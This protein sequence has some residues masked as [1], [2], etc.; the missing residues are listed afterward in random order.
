MP[1]DVAESPD[2]IDLAPPDVLHYLEGNG[3]R[4][5]LDEREASAQF[6]QEE[7]VTP[8]YDR[9]LVKDKKRY[10]RFVKDLNQRGLLRFTLHPKEFVGVFFVWKKGRLKMR[11]I[12]DGRRPNRR[13]RRPPKARL[14]TSEGL[15]EIEVELPA[16]VDPLSP[17][18][19]ALLRALGLGL[20]VAD[21]ADC[22]HRMIMPTWMSAYFCVSSV[23]ARDVGLEGHSVDGVVLGQDNEVFPCA[24]ALPMGFSWSLWIAQRINEHRMSLC[25]CL[26]NSELIADNLPPAVFTAEKDSLDTSHFVCVDNLGVLSKDVGEV[27]CAMTEAGESFNSVDLKLHDFDITEDSKVTLGTQLDLKNLRSAVSLPR[28][29][30]LKMGLRHSLRRKTLSGWALEMLLGHCTFCGLT[31]RDL[32]CIFSTAY[33]FV[34]AHYFEVGTVWDTV[35]EELRMFH[36]RMCYLTSDWWLQWN[37]L[38]NESDASPYGNGVCTSQWPR[39]VVA[40]VGRLRER[41]RFKLRPGCSARSSALGAAGLESFDAV[42][43]LVDAAEAPGQVTVEAGESVWEVDDGFAEVPVGRLRTDLWTPKL[44]GKWNFD[45]NILMLDARTLVMALKRVAVSIF[46]HDIRQ[47]NLVDNMS[48]CFSFER[49]RAKDFKLLVQIRRFSAYCLARNIK[50]FVRWVPSELNA[51]DAPSR[52]FDPDCKFKHEKVV[53]QQQQQRQH[54]QQ[55]QQQQNESVTKRNKTPP[56]ESNKSS[57]GNSNTPRSHESSSDVPF[58]CHRI[59]IHN[60]HERPSVSKTD[61]GGGGKF[62]TAARTENSSRADSA[63][64]G[65]PFF[66]GAGPGTANED[67]AQG[68]PTCA[69]CHEVAKAVHISA[70]RTVGPERR[71]AVGSDADPRSFEWKWRFGERERGRNVAAAQSADTAGEEPPSCESFASGRGGPDGGVSGGACRPTEDEA[72]LYGTFDGFRVFCPEPK[73]YSTAAREYRGLDEGRLDSGELFRPS[74]FPRS[75]GAYGREDNGVVHG[76]VPIIRS[77]WILELTPRLAVSESLE[78]TGAR[79]ISISAGLGFLVRDC[80]GDSGHERGHDGGIHIDAGRGI[81]PSS[82]VPRPREDG[83]AAASAGHLRVLDDDHRARAFGQDHEDWRDGR[84]CGARRSSRSMATASLAEDGGGRAERPAVELRLSELLEGLQG[85]DRGAENPGCAIPSTAFGT[86][87]RSSTE[88]ADAGRSA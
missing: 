40:S 71:T 20:G 34:E 7:Y 73:G 50:A 23:R 83:F 51:S 87:N 2:V 21:V 16:D 26:E 63:Y 12:L 28:F 22:F 10:R 84:Q 45:E 80:N 70:D 6:L 24:R 32:L 52:I 60:T 31:R 17:E 46:G 5:L 55:Q 9:V 35:R 85:R 65:G 42:D 15:A 37:E 81:L 3:E 72:Q 27:K 14:C 38:V 62:C 44:F 53:Q 74:V 56:R 61:A 66:C 58:F 19:V 13:F 78:A 43:D 8:Y 11:L 49:R 75:T 67:A 48:V 69:S 39:A 86:V 82:R 47:L 54:V 36:G 30:R 59:S 41:R 79:T 64:W 1:A 57:V 76:Q 88:F 77:S 29:W 4:M 68:A 33:K 18:G 25:P